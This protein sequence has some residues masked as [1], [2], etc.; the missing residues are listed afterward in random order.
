MRE[1][2]FIIG[3]VVCRKLE[4][5]EGS[6]TQIDQLSAN[7]LI[8]NTSYLKV[9]DVVPQVMCCTAGFADCSKASGVNACH[10]SMNGSCCTFS[11]VDTNT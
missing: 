4:C 8:A 2:Y 10:M 11:F 7:C 9:D 5:D 1:N 3:Q 6:G